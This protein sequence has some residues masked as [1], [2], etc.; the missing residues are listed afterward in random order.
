MILAVNGR[1]LQGASHGE[2]VQRLKQ[3]GPTVLL[4]IKPNQVLQGIAKTM[5]PR[6]KSRYI[7]DVLLA[8]V[9]SMNG[10]GPS[11]ETE[12]EAEVVAD[13]LEPGQAHEGP[14]PA[15]WERKIDVRTGRPYYEK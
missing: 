2:A 14:L 9:F 8:D 1:S 7:S 13:S 12:G 4:R 3:A 5:Q 6:M 15:G 11:P 10:E